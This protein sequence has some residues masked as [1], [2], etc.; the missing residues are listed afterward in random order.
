M[1]FAPDSLRLAFVQIDS[2]PEPEPKLTHKIRQSSRPADG[3]QMSTEISLLNRSDC[4]VTV[5]VS[6]GGYASFGP[7]L[8]VFSGR[9]RVVALEPRSAFLLETADEGAN[10][11]CPEGEKAATC[12]EKTQLPGGGCDASPRREGCTTVKGGRSV[13]IHR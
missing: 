4:P 11:T 7:E 10:V 1:T 6:T 3:R 5:E 13:A 2:E 12:G 8:M 9:T